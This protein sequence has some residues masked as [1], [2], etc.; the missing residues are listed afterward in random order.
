MELD[1]TGQPPYLYQQH[2]QQQKLQQHQQQQRQDLQTPPP[3]PSS[4]LRAFD[5]QTGNDRLTFD[6]Q[7]AARLTTTTITADDL[8]LGGQRLTADDLDPSSD[9]RMLDLEDELRL[10]EIIEVGKFTDG[11]GPDDSTA[12]LETMLGP[13]TGLGISRTLENS[14][15]DRGTYIYTGFHVFVY[16]LG[17]TFLFEVSKICKLLQKVPKILPNS[18]LHWFVKFV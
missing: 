5:T 8:Q 15:N 4:R 12:S 18:F 6:L 17:M 11:L 10:R 2:L 1:S 3:P 13:V 9:D 16:F 7:T 14:I